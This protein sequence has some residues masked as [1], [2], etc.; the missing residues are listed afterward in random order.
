MACNLR[1]NH[2][3]VAV[4]ALVFASGTFAGT[5]TYNGSAS[6]QTTPMPMPLANGGAVITTSATGVAAMTE[7][8]ATAPILFSVRCSGLGYAATEKV[9]GIRFFCTFAEDAQN[10]F[11]VNGTEKAGKTSIEVIGGNGRWKGATGKGE[12]KRTAAGENMSKST[13]TLE[14]TTP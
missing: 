2:F 9:G 1:L 7:S 5:K 14:I 4:A 12:F 10:G 13:F 6:T 3:L 11:D 8:G